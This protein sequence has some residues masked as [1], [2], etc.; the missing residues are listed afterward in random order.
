MAMAKS[1]HCRVCDLS[2]SFDIP[3]MLCRNSLAARP[4]GHP[5]RPL[6]LIQLATVHLGDAAN[7]TQADAYMHEVM[8]LDST[9][10]H[11]NR[12]AFFVVHLL[13]GLRTSTYQAGGHSPRTAEFCISFH[14]CGSMGFGDH[15]LHQFEWFGDLADLKQAITI[16]EAH[17]SHPCWFP[18]A[19]TLQASESWYCIPLPTPSDFR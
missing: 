3:L 12:A 7:K 9:E 18:I 6:M 1:I 10:G 5:D 2:A 14:R 4:A 8:E 13:A 15:P 17:L 11:E 16:L 19:N